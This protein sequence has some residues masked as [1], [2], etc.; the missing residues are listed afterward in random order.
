MTS[1]RY[2][3]SFFLK[4]FWGLVCLAVAAAFMLA[5][6]ALHQVHPLGSATYAAGAVITFPIAALLLRDSL[7]SLRT[8]RFDREIELG[9][10]PRRRLSRVSKSRYLYQRSDYALIFA[11]VWFGVSGICSS[12]YGE[13][14]ASEIGP[15]CL[16][17]AFVFA[18]IAGSFFARGLNLRRKAKIRAAG[19]LRP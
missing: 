13:Y 18:A 17:G 14:H 12:L 16:L 9:K 19:E 8:Y 4:L 15:F 5:M 11:A 1:A 7:R 6:V 2:K 10:A 3:R